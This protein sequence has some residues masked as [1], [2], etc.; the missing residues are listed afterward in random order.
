[1][2]THIHTHSPLGRQIS[3]PSLPT[4]D[5][6]SGNFGDGKQWGLQFGREETAAL[7]RGSSLIILTEAI[8]S[9]R[10]VIES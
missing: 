10:P 1:M 3:C 8:E 5:V 4:G 6:S 9:L 7:D 2:H